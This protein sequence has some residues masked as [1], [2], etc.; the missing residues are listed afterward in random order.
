MTFKIWH[1]L[2]IV[3]NGHLHHW[4]QRQEYRLEVTAKL[5]SDCQ[6]FGGLYF[7]P[8]KK[9]LVRNCCWRIKLQVCVLAYSGL[10]LRTEY[11]KNVWAGRSAKLI[12]SCLFTLKS[13]SC[14]WW[15]IPWMVSWSLSRER[16]FPLL[17]P[18]LFSVFSPSTWNDLP[19]PLWQK[20]FL[21]SFK[22][23]LKIFL[24]PKQ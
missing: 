10:K 22:S 2:Y 4:Q 5:G 9:E 7:W 21:D 8:K 17:V 1:Y 13:D 11:A 3:L 6:R 24:F 23:N 15:L 18:V 19:L 16:D 12:S 14:S 20:T